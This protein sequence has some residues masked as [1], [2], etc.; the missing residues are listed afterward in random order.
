MKFLE[1]NNLLSFVIITSIAILSTVILEQCNSIQVDAISDGQNCAFNYYQIND[2]S[3]WDSIMEATGEIE[4]AF[5]TGKSYFGG[6][7][8]FKKSINDTIYSLYFEYY[9]NDTDTIFVPFW[10]YKRFIQDDFQHV[11]SFGEGGDTL[12]YYKAELF[13]RLKKFFISGE[14]YYQY[15]FNELKI[16]ERDYFEKH[17]DSLT[18]VKGSNLPPLPKLDSIQMRLGEYLAQ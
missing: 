4:N 1:I 9:F 5:Q 15:E 18:R 2:R 14:Y 8:A 6:Y 16:H 13:G 7:Y 12:Y 3:E 17:K 11:L 10:L